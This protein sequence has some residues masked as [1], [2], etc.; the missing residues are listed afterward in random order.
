MG[1]KL[2]SWLNSALVI[3]V[4]FVILI[5]AWLIVALAGRA[6]GIP[7]GLDLW[8]KLWQPVFTP[9]LGIMMGGAVLSG[10]VSQVV[11]RLPDKQSNQ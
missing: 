7:L 2:L 4:F 1:S 6:A 9:A 10:A 8:Y 3:D 11:K 5:L